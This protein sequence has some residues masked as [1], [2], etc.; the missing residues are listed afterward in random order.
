MKVEGQVLKDE[1]WGMS[2]VPDKAWLALIA[3]FV[4]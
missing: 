4:L 2:K 1:G 3:G